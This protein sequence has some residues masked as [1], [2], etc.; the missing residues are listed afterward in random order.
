MKGG[1]I[2]KDANGHVEFCFRIAVVFP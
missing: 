1:I 2:G